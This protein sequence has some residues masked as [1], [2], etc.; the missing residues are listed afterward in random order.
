MRGE[1]GLGSRCLATAKTLS[2]LPTSF[3]GMR[4]PD[5]GFQMKVVKDFDILWFYFTTD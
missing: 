5:S 1:V 4:L 2:F 3:Y